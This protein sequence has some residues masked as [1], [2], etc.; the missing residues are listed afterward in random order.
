MLAYD[1]LSPSPLP[2]SQPQQQLHIFS[3]I[4][5]GE[6]NFAWGNFSLGDG[7][8]ERKN[9]GY[10]FLYHSCSTFITALTYGIARL[11]NVVL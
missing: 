1:S 9:L 6:S 10:T 7:K 3:N 4:D 11:I 8:K 2:F 5:V